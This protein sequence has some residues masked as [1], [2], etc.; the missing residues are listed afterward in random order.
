MQK[1]CCIC[2]YEFASNHIN[3]PKNMFIEP[4]NDGALYYFNLWHYPVEK[5]P[6]CDYASRDISKTLNKKIIDDDK[7]KEINTIPILR[8]LNEARPTSIDVYLKSAYYYESIGNKLNSAKSL[9][10]A[11]DLVYAEMLYWEEY[12]LDSSD[13]VS[14]LISRS[15]YNEMK[16]FAD[17]L[18]SDGLLRLESYVKENPEDLDAL[19]LLAGT[20][21]DGNKIQNIKAARIL[22]A[23]KGM[24]LNIDQKRAIEFLIEGIS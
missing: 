5:C 10:Q 2:G 19:I 14:A 12:I 13:S 18:F 15:E 11:G 1:K 21:S 22:T 3:Y 20:L 23:L 9:F 4:H 24:P 16:K 6:Q 8:E 17:G 7:Y